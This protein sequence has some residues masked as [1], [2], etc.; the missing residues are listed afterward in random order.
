[1]GPKGAV[2]IIF[3]SQIE[4]AADPAARGDAAHARVPREVREPR[5]SAAAR[6]YID[7][8]I[9][10]RTTRPRLIAGL[11]A[12]REQA[13]QEPAAQA[14]EHPAV[15][16]R[17]AI[18]FRRDP[19]REPRRDRAPHH[20]RLPRAR[21]RG[22]RRLERRRPRGALRAPRGRGRADRRARSR[23]GRTSTRT[24]SSRRPAR[25]R[26]RRDPPGLRVPVRERRLRARG[27]G[28]RASCSSA[29][30][31][32]RSRRW[33]TRSAAARPCG[34]PACPVIPGADHVSPATLE[35]AA[36]EIGFPLMLKASAGG[37]G[38]GI[39]IVASPAELASAFERA[40][41]GGPQRVRRRRRLPREGDRAAAP[42]RGPGLRR[43]ARQRS[44][45][46]SSASARCS[47]ATRR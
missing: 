43:L 25:S 34:P 37:G 19:D 33:A 23:S 18:P 8:V 31:P 42:R 3:K 24:R 36:R 9:D 16:G 13:R 21:D 15:T 29:R 38:K 32:T 47:G 40:R 12:A 4:N 39:R 45:T 44:C 17:R 20:P 35:A 22:R 26:G 10:P 14:R 28:A 46:C 41:V 11:R 7:D 5:S 27:A 30:A 1:M 2:E 6:G